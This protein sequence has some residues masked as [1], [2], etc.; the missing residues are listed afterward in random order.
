MILDINK[1][2]NNNYK[3]IFINESNHKYVEFNL[4]NVIN[5]IFIIEI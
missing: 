3:F 1:K 2:L 4:I 5:K